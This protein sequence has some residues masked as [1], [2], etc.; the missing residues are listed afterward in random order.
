MDR[1][2][3]R[4]Y[5]LIGITVSAAFMIGAPAY[6]SEGSRLTMAAPPGFED[7]AAERQLLLD[8]W[9]G[10]RKLGE[11]RV[12]VA[13]G[14]LTFED[15][16]AVAALVP[17]VARPL[18]L[19]QALEGPLETNVS[20]LCGASRDEGCGTIEPSAAGVIL[21]EERFRVDLFVN[22]ALLETPDQASDAYLDRPGAEPSL[23][24]LFGAT[25]SGSNRGD[26]S[27]HVQNR[28]I[29][30]VGSLRVRSDMSL[31]SG[32][33]VTIDN[34]AAEKDLKDWRYIAGIFWA[35]GTELV[36]RRR[37][38]GIGATTQ[39]DTLQDR[40]A[41]SATPLVLALQHQA[42]V[43]LLVDGRLVSS[44]I[45]PAGNR[46]VDTEA[47]PGG[48]YEVLLRIQEDGLP[49]RIERRFF[50]RGTLM[51]PLGRPQFAAFAGILPS[52][53]P[54]LSL[55]HGDAFYQLSASYRVAPRIGLDA[56]VLG[57]GRK[58]IL[59]G[60]VVWQSGLAQV[61]L[62]ALLSSSLDYGASIRAS[63]SGKGPLAFSF[64]LRTIKSRDGR[65]LMPVASSRGTFSE[66]PEAGF[67]DRGS[68]T[69]AIGVASYRLGDANF[70]LTG[71]YRRGGTEDSTYSIGAS[72]DMPVIRTGRWDIV[73]QADVRK[74]EHELA[75]FLGVRFLLNR[76]ELA[77]SGSAGTIHQSGRPGDDERLVGEAQLAWARTLANEGQLSTDAAI[78]RDS[79]GS[80]ARASAYAR[81]PLVNAR[82][83][84]LHQF[85][86]LATTQYAA[87]L[88]SGFVMSGHGVGMSGRE[89]N[90]SA[91][92]VSADGIAPGQR[93]ELL[94]DEVARGTV[95]ADRTTRVF[96]Q[97]YRSYHIR[98]RPLGAQ[99]A[100]FDTAA[101]QVTLYP[102]S[103][104]ALHWDVT[105]LFVLFGQA[106]DGLGRPVAN[107]EIKGAFGI[108][109][110]DGEGY[111]QIETRSGDVLGFEPASAPACA[112]TVGKARQRDG[113][114]SGGKV[115]CR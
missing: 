12:R 57:T 82:A 46:L 66:D 53:G 25:L 67:G 32:T 107:A 106:V 89:M 112:V 103:V 36:G 26:Q 59:D 56:S 94:V 22:P 41:L 37:I 77:L 8:V 43:E 38:A 52:A 71:L 73:V 17:E 5:A 110:S 90:D 62:S 96:L 44:R 30:A 97:P 55:D 74:S 109:R 19:R 69:Q 24:S 7:L 29:A 75:S 31:S 64:D 34:L 49:V 99:A 4:A 113:Y 47:L 18:E 93:F 48:S 60:G 105:P 9:F 23:I 101:R 84:L 39:L 114:V 2:R 15:P 61:R 80:Y 10:G 16:A 27:W 86:D 51:A 13:P 100:S 111:F 58:A 28:T 11:A 72:V 92:E 85:G 102:G 95:G 81:T 91:V 42:R 68:Y 63:S 40:D 45:Y 115:Q 6:A 14:L 104:A 70:R 20:R 78:G 1:R 88:E 108:G 83:D 21:D 87:T 76:G 98:L 33:G 54:G 3:P 65:P 35:P 79:D 50:S